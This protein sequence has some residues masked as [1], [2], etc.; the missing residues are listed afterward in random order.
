MK[1]FF[2]LCARLKIDWKRLI[3]AGA[4]M[5][6][7]GYPPPDPPRIPVPYRLQKF[8]WSL[9]PKEALVYAKKRLSMPPQKY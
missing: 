5:T 8:I 6:T 4:I 1:E 9:T 3:L 7:A 2:R